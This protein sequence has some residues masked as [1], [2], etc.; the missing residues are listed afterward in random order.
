MADNN[1]QPE[2]QFALQRIFVKDLS[3]ESPLGAKV[4]TQQWK[5]QI[6][7]DLNTRSN[8]FDENGNFEVILKITVTAR[9]EEEVAF[10]AEVE[11]AG[12]FTVRGIEG[13]DLRRVLAIGCPNI[14]FPYARESL[15]ALC[16]KGS[17][18][19][20]MLQ[21]VNFE[22]LYIQASQQQK[23]QAETGAH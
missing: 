1:Q 9:I 15:D 3:F 4:F 8:R 17:F 5:P 23:Q 6:K 14:L 10:L 22:A 13:E 19:P 20:L 12:L 7:V 16:G 21:P 2:Q 11:Q 18:P